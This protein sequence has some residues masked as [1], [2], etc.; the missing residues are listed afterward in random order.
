MRALGAGEYGSRAVFILMLCLAGPAAWTSAA[1]A[2]SVNNDTV[3]VAERVEQ[4]LRG[5][6]AWPPLSLEPASRRHAI[7]YRIEELPTS[8][9][10]KSVDFIILL[11]PLVDHILDAYHLG[12]Q[13]EQVQAE[14]R[15]LEDLRNHAS[16]VIRSDAGRFSYRNI[17]VRIIAL[18][19]DPE[20]L[21]KISEKFVA[22]GVDLRF[23]GGHH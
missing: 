8:E 11:D 1:F 10:Y 9:K 17:P 16:L 19:G 5:T 23:V 20:E 14:A 22:N 7:Q 18:G 4:Q 2:R 12:Y 3:L 13:T 6:V 15:Y 21:M